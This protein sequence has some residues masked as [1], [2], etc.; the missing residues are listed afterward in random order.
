MS[1]RGWVVWQVRLWGGRI[2]VHRKG[3]L[4]SH[5][6]ALRLALRLGRAETRPSVRYYIRPVGRHLTRELARYPW[7]VRLADAAPAVRPR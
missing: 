6:S 2:C 5:E 7:A 3:V 1:E 4:A